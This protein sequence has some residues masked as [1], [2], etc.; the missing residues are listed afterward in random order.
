MGKGRK[1]CCDK[2]GVKRGP[3][4][5]AED[6]KL[7]SFIQNHGH[8]N[9]RALPK[10]AGLARC[11]KSCRLRWVNYLRPDLKRGD[12][13]PHEE[14][15]IIKLHQVLGNKWSKI[16]SHFPGRTDNEI[17]NVWNTHLKKRLKDKGSN[18][19]S[20][21]SL[22]SSSSSS[23]CNNNTSS[24]P[25]EVLDGSNKVQQ[26]LI[27]HQTIIINNNNN[28]NNNNN[29]DN[30]NNVEYSSSSST[31]YNSQTS[32]SNHQITI[33][34]DMNPSMVE[35]VGDHKDETME[36]YTENILDELIEIPYEP[37]LDLWELLQGENEVQFKDVDTPISENDN[38][39]E[40]VKQGGE[41]WWWLVYLENELGLD[42]QNHQSTNNDFF[43]DINF[44]LSSPN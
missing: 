24:T 35:N 37:N 29:D 32:F 30:D 10:L 36:N 21:V 26:V 2:A 33:N 6:F 39:N 44:H 11:G 40:N 14:E 12:F 34:N 17:K 16:A 9:W 42:H 23:S 13:N 1:P 7:I 22:S 3:W 18:N 19:D 43:S 31:S 5:Q 20:Q 15:A 41:S 8:N 38:K 27:A 4:S 28:N 25:N